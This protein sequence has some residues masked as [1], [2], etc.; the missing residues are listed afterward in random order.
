MSKVENAVHI[1]R[2]GFNCSQAVF[3]AY[4]EQL[5]LNQETA[6]K[7]ACPFGAGI[8][9]TAETCG[10]VTGAY[11]LIGLKY[12]KSK[13]EDN[14]AKEKSYAL[15]K[16]FNEKFK[17]LHGSILC[18]EL[19][20]YDMKNPEDLRQIKEEGLWD[21]LCPVFVRDS[22]RIIEKLLELE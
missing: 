5:G 12:G 16:E 7:I 3:S 1:F 2:N 14:E 4:S 10:A 13:P 9:R 18:K 22:A 11:M 19:L 8:G 17:E 20:N 21:T 15:V 6:L